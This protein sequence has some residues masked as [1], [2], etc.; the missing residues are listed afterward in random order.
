MGGYR[1]LR[2]VGVLEVTRR[3]HGPLCSCGSSALCS[4]CVRA[5]SHL[6]FWVGALCIKIGCVLVWESQ[7]PRGGLPTSFI[8]CL[9]RY[10]SRSPS[11]SIFLELG[12][13]MNA[14]ILDSDCVVMCSFMCLSVTPRGATYHPQSRRL[15]IIKSPP[16][17]QMVQHCRL[18][19]MLRLRAMLRRRPR[20]LLRSMSTW[21]RRS[22]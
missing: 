22:V 8:A 6:L 11:Y 13:P 15:L 3:R 21:R 18:Q 14:M 5:C 1:S 20:R 9:I 4:R 10:Q 7:S 12:L 17:C 2:G 16:L 19:R